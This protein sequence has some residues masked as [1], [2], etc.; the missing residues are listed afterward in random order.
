MCERKILLS[1]KSVQDVI[2]KL[3]NSHVSQIFT[4]CHHL[5][6]FL[7]VLQ[8]SAF[9]IKRRTF[10]IIGLKAVRVSKSTT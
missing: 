6:M 10:L 3:G 2:R 7:F 5:L 9:L 8:Y 4:L 1:F